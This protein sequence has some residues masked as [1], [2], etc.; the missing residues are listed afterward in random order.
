[1]PRSHVIVSTPFPCYKI[2][3]LG[4]QRILMGIHMQ[5]I[6]PF[7]E[8]STGTGNGRLTRLILQLK[9]VTSNVY[10]KT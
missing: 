1:M 7:N 10:C 3:Y 2:P 4:N 9:V 8:N 6:M 5:I